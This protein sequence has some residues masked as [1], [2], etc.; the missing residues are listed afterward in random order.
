LLEVVREEAQVMDK[1]L[2][3]LQK[4]NERLKALIAVL[5]I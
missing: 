3:E 1:K 4:E 5:P 2:S